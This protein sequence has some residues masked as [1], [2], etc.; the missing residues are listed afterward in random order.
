LAADPVTSLASRIGT[1]VTLERPSDPAHGDYATNAAL[2][3]AGVRRQAPREL[4]AEL[5]EAAQALPEVERAEIAGPGF[6]NVF[7]GDAWYA[8][9]LAEILRAGDAF[10]GGFA[11]PRERDP[12]RVRADVLDGFVSREAAAR[13]YGVAIE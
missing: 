5:V 6:V 9:A 2:R 13:D 11:D 10:G 3:L 1:G 12:D 4:A 7:L 8:D